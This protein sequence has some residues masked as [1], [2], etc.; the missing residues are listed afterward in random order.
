MKLMQLSL[1]PTSR[2]ALLALLTLI[3]SAATT[4]ASGADQPPPLPREFRA[5]WVA[6]VANIDW[7]S[8]PGLSTEVQKR[9]A[10]A[11]LD[12]ARDMNLNAIVLQIRTSADALYDSKLETWSAFLTGEQGKR[13]SPYYDPLQF[14][15]EEAHQRG[16]QLHAWFNP[17]RARLQGVKYKES[18]D[19]ISKTRPDLTKE[20]GGFLWLDP[21]E[22]EAREHTLRVFMDVVKRYDVD[23]IHVDD[24]FYPY[25]IIDPANPKS[26]K[27]L[28]FPDDA[29]WKK[30]QD[31]GGKLERGDWRRDNMNQLIER[32]Y[33]GIKAEKPSVLFGISPF[34]VPR[35]GQPKGVVGF[36]QYEKLYADTVLWLNKGWC[37][38][39]APQLYWKID[40]PGQPFR[41]LLNHWVQENKSKR[42]IWPGLTS[43]RIGNG[44]RSYAP[45]ELL[46]QVEIIR[47]TPGAT[48]EIFFSM[49][50]LMENKRDFSDSLK[51]GLYHEP[52][53]I[54]ASPWLQLPAPGL[55]QGEAHAGKGKLEL[56]VQAGPGAPP[57]LWAVSVRHGEHWTVSLH[58]A[59]N[60][61]L[62]VADDAKEPAAQVAVTAVSRAGDASDP[63]VLPIS[64]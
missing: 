38:Y 3:G 10:I 22:P 49:R 6:T 63:V 13:P 31:S 17:F 12:R 24:Y 55:P 59:T 58:P 50:S 5:A 35:P 48:G 34:G 61:P 15:I 1:K 14:W 9:E 60:G 29:S 27:E 41:P 46:G 36:D 28:D 16:L 8:K 2:L 19:H 20:Y 18:A 40:A 64:R 23:G 56:T 42:H 4:T 37:D 51:K 39:F 30:Y 54:P 57:F 52:A 44:E 45:E 62:V 32:I 21:G 53:L 33:Q 47:Q 43:S 25:P 11:I 7:P 26:N